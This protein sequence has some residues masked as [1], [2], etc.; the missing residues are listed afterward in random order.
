MGSSSR[1]SKCRQRYPY[2]KEKFGHTNTRDAHT[3]AGQCEDMM[4][5]RPSE[6]QGERS[7]ETKP[8]SYLGLR[9]PASRTVRK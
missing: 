5:R 2:K 9:L 6:S 1:L 4:G 7:G 3:G 8:V